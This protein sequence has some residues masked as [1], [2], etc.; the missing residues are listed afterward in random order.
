MF[1]FPLRIRHP[2]SH[3]VRISIFIAGICALLP[4]VVP[5]QASPVERLFVEFANDLR[6]SLGLEPLVLMEEYRKV[7]LHH[8]AYIYRT[9]D[10]SH[11]Q[12]RRLAG[13]YFFATGSDRNE[14]FGPEG[15]WAWSE[16]LTYGKIPGR[17]FFQFTD[18]ALARVCIANFLDSPP[19]KGVLLNDWTLDCTVG[20]ISS[21]KKYVCVVNFIRGAS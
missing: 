17:Q 11:T 5:A 19:H 21:G 6:D 13:R 18:S 2:V 8:A 15:S 3:H 7:S 16:I 1:F 4:I 10:V 9:D 20:I 14:A 12:D